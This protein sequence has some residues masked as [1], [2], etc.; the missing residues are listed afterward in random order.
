MCT[1]VGH[2]FNYQTCFLR[3]PP[4][5]C[6]FLLS[7]S[8]PPYYQGAM[9]QVRFACV[10]LTRGES[11]LVWSSAVIRVL[12]LPIRAELSLLPR[13]YRRSTARLPPASWLSRRPIGF[14]PPLRSGLAFIAAHGCA[15]RPTLVPTPDEFPMNFETVSVSLAAFLSRLEVLFAH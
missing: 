15:C 7:L 11:H 3:M 14:A 4:P 6:I 12:H 1:S 5:L 2:C 8:C 10:G 9:S 13:H